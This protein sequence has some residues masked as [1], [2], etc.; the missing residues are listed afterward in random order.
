MSLFLMLSQPHTVDQEIFAVKNFF[1][2]CL[3]SEN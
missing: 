1:A 3:G 2:S